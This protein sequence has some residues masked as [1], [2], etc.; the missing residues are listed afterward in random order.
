MQTIKEL[1][2]RIGWDSAFC[3]AEFELG[4]WDRVER[5]VINVS[6]KSLDIGTG[7]Q[8][9]LPHKLRWAYGVKVN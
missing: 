2:S 9:L 6:L 1:L 5:K 3:D 4:Y 8:L 7:G